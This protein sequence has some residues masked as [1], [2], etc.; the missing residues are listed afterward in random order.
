M[1]PNSLS[2]QLVHE[3]PLL[4]VDDTVGEAVR[5][6]LDSGLPALPVAD[7]EGRLCGIFGERE[8]MDALFPGYLK[9]LSYAG[10]VPSKLD[11]A[12]EQRAACRGEAVSRH[13]NTE[14]VD[15]GRDASDAAIAET[16]MHHSVLVLPVCADGRPVGIITRRDFFRALAK[17]FLEAG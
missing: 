3:A 11:E 10:F 2:S 12:L 1:S 16:F 8:F 6:I 5:R 7:S 13:M 17:R 15:V 4:T 9:E 14:H